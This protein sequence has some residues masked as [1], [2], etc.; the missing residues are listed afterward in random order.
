MRHIAPAAGCRLCSSSPSQCGPPALA[1]AAPC[2]LHP[3]MSVVRVRPGSARVPAHAWGFIALYLLKPVHAFVRAW[4]CSTNPADYA[5]GT[6]ATFCASSNTTVSDR[7]QP[8]IF[9]TSQSGSPEELAASVRYMTAHRTN[10]WS[11]LY[12]EPW[13]SQVFEKRT[14]EPLAHMT[15]PLGNAVSWS[16]QSQ[17][18]LVPVSARSR[19]DRLLRTSVR[20]LEQIERDTVNF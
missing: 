20:P 10:H 16:V 1:S 11:Q 13:P 14:I 8:I 18:R 6:I 15:A 17:E 12:Q 5:A 9:P 19:E 4:V 2:K 3:H 7:R